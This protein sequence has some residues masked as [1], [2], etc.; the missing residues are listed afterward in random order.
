MVLC[1]GWLRCL[2]ELLQ[3]YCELQV[4]WRAAGASHQPQGLQER[5]QAPPPPPVCGPHNRQDKAFP[6]CIL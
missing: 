6:H 5:V 4:R 2:A 1:D 3:H